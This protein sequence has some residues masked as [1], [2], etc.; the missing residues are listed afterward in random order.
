MNQSEEANFSNIILGFPSDAEDR[1]HLK[2]WDLLPLPISLHWHLHVG[3]SFPRIPVSTFIGTRASSAYHFHRF[4]LPTTLRPLGF[5]HLRWILRRS[6]YQ[7]LIA[8]RTRSKPYWRYSF[9]HQAPPLELINRF[10][11]RGSSRM[12]Y[13]FLL[14]PF[15]TQLRRRSGTLT[16]LP[17]FL[18]HSYR[19]LAP[20]CFRSIRDEKL[21]LFFLHVDASIL[22]RHYG[23]SNFRA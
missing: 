12:S 8:E 9:T 10:S 5:D 6:V 18:V 23:T 7:L 1:L 22:R 16:H 19:N 4:C 14:T 2:K 13:N 20:V 3:R 11:P 21:I 17:P 15:R